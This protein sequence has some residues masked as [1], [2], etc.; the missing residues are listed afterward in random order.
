MTNRYIPLDLLRGL[1]IFGM[2]FSAIIPYGD[3]PAWMYHIQNPP[4]THQLDIS[5][6]GIGWVDFVFP[7]F[8]FCMGVS[9]PFAGRKRIESSGKGIKQDS[10][11]DTDATGGDNENI[12]NRYVIGVLERFG[13]LWLFSYL[14]IFVNYSQDHGWQSYIATIIGFIL[15]F[16]IYYAFPKEGK[17]MKYKNKIRMY[18]WV[19]MATLIVFGYLRFNEEISLNRSG[20]I[21]FLLAFLYLFGSLIWYFTRDNHK[22]RLF[23]F[24]AI[25]LFAAGT[26]PFGL[27]PKLYA[28]PEIRWFFNM[29]YIYFLLIVIP[30]TYIGDI[31]RQRLLSGS[32]GARESENG[33]SFRKRE[34]SIQKQKQ[35]SQKTEQ[36]IQKQEHLSQ[37]GV[38]STGKE[39]EKSGLSAWKREIIVAV[40]AI[41][42]GVIA[43]TIEGGVTKVPCTVSYCLITLGVSILLLLL[44]DRIVFW[45]EN[46]YTVRTFAGAGANPLLSYVAFGSFIMPLMELTGF[47]YVYNMFYPT[48][49]PWIGVLRAF[50]FVLLTLALVAKMSENKIFWRA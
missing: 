43:I 13:M 41:I 39:V 9:I 45:A 47:I 32:F 10:G 42:T 21:I 22:H 8:I 24:I 50:V 14:Y 33:Q 3:L 5:V 36:L 6:T 46:S 18:G 38:Q 30:A 28:I 23:A 27:Q 26:M 2:I 17:L 40:V 44:A 34:R 37:R 25:L 35:S 31:L 1:A 19:A 4:P 48:G 11:T 49:Y 12:T 7:L 16:V 29:E 20:I 15:L